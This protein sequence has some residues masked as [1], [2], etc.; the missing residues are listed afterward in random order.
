M[1][2]R[3]EQ[4]NEWPSRVANLRLLYSKSQCATHAMSYLKF[5]LSVGKGESSSCS[6]RICHVNVTSG[7]MLA[8]KNQQ[9]VQQTGGE[10]YQVTKKQG[11]ASEVV[12]TH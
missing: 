5:V 12:Q 10:I 7:R 9:A 2:N 4:H 6:F 8:N 1:N 11:G 3:M